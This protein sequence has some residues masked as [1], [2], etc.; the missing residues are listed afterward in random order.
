M[1]ASPNIQFTFLACADLNEIWE[2]IAMPR[3]MW[4]YAA[5]ENLSTAESFS[6][7]FQRVC[8]LLPDHPEIASN[9]DGLLAGV[10]SVLCNR[11]AIFFRNRGNCVEILRVLR[12]TNDVNSGVAA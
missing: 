4:G 11:Y 5:S 3:D 6:L 10:H 12:A 1:K 8:A 7:Q 2:S 9:R